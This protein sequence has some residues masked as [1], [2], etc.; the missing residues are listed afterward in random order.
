LSDLL[1]SK[2]ETE[3]TKDN[4]GRYRIEPL[5]KGFSV[6]LGNALRRILLGFLE[7]AAVTRVKIEGIQHEFS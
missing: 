6:T 1:V 4:Y 5:E 2:V 7:G 3:E